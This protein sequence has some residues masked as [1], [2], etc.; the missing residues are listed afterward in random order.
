MCDLS[1]PSTW[2]TGDQTQNC[3]FSEEK[4][5]FCVC[6]RRKL[7]C[8]LQRDERGGHGEVLVG[9]ELAHGL[10]VERRG[11]VLGVGVTT[12]AS[13]AGDASRMSLRDLSS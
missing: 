6:S 4:G 7:A 13:A 2:T 1:A 5:Q 9:T 10:D 11:E 12:P 3:P 8:V